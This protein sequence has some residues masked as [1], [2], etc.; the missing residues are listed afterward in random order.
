MGED[1]CGVDV[2][3]ERCIRGRCTWPEWYIYMQLTESV[4]G[5]C[6]T[7]VLIF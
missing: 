4:N 2:M 6:S 7:L 5:T 3:F 1:A